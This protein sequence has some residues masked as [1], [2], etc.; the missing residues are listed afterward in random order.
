MEH[1]DEPDKQ[2]ESHSLI[3]FTTIACLCAFILFLRNPGYL[4]HARFFGEDGAV[5][6]RDQILWGVSA[7][8]HTSAGYLHIVPRLL[9]QLDGAVPVR[10]APFSY[11]LESILI[12]GFCCATFALDNFRAILASDSLRALLCLLAAAAFPAEEIVG[13]LTNLQWFLIL[14]ATPFAI[15]P[16][17][18]R[19]RVQ[20]ILFVLLSLLISLSAPLTIVLIPL[21]FLRAFRTRRLAPF[22]LGLLAG[23]IIEW[24]VIA[25]HGAAASPVLHSK[26][27]IDH[28]VFSILVAFANQIVAFMLLGGTKTYLLFIR[29][30]KSIGLLFLVAFTCWQTVLYVKGSPRYRALVRVMLWLIFSSVLLADVRQMA[31]VFTQVTSAQPFGA[32]RYFLLGCWC[33]AFLLIWGLDN[34]KPQWPASAKA[35]VIALILLY[36]ASGNFLLAKRSAPSW[37]SLAPQIE[38]WK[39]DRRMGHEH[40]PVSAPIDPPGWAVE[41]PS[42]G[43]RSY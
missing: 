18:A 42:L 9:A 5:F 13:T 25:L 28:L 38:S 21:L 17:S 24:I 19:H 15:A 16:P 4:N 3:R 14:A 40:A 10:A 7:L 8:L 32:H 22:D 23:T 26:Q 27:G 1:R 30:Y 43:A 31:E 2:P 6:F 35:A 11:A 33:F 36:G 41:L 37:G 39:A 12:G 34:V 29:G 20:Q